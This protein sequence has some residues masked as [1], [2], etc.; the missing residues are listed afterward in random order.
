MISVIL[1]FL[2]IGGI[3]FVGFISNF[4]FSRYKIPDV[5]ILIFLGVLIG[6]GL[7]GV[8]DA[9]MFV[10]V[11][12]MA[13]FLAALALAMIMFDGG[14]GLNY[15]QVLRSITKT[16]LHSILVFSLSIIITTGVCYFFLGWDLMVSLLLGS[17]LGGT[18]GAIVIPI[19]NRM[20]ISGETKALLTIES[21]LTDVMVIVMAMS[22]LFFLLEG[23]GGV[24]IAIRNLV[25]AFFV[26]FMIGLITGIV[27]LKVLAKL[28]NQPFSYMV[29]IATLLVMYGGTDLLVGSTGVGAIAALIFGLVLGNK[30][31]FAR[32]FKK[33]KGE[34]K[35]NEE[36]RG[37][38]AEITFFVRTFFFVYLGIVFSMTPVNLEYVVLG[39]G[40]FLGLLGIRAV[41]SR[42]TGAVLNMNEQ[43]R[44]A[45]FFMMPRGLS[46]AVLA[47][48]PLVHQ[49]VSAEVASAI[50][51]VTLIVIVLSTALAC[52]GAFTVEN[53]SPSPEERKRQSLR[54][55]SRFAAKWMDSKESEGEMEFFDEK[56]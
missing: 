53:T 9:E 23:V 27:W 6:P 45:V 25:S 24:D 29:T 39:L 32:I 21:A 40:I 35:F 16:M 33:F 50:L 47:S 54:S 56:R 46:A 43:D 52:V 49:V 26:S 19:V 20:R 55:K 34:F 7:L 51:S 2:A 48:Y 18:S 37:F 38:H 15:D 30:D 4:L 17:I 3:I 36:I 12:D 8:V 41:T 1:A 22:I 28:E 11:E 42:A 10:L 31:E 5:L 13:P 44:M 14:M